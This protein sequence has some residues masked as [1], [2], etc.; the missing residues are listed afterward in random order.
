MQEEK[1]IYILFREIRT[2]NIQYYHLKKNG[3]SWKYN[4]NKHQFLSNTNI[5]PISIYKHTKST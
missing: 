2:F 1:G 4:K 3:I 5:L